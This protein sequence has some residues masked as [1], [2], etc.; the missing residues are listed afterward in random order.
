M[1]TSDTPLHVFVATPAYDHKLDSRYVGCLLRLWSLIH[2]LGGR[3]T[4]PGL[5]GKE[6][7]HASWWSQADSL[8]PRSRNHYVHEFLQGPA[9][10]TGLP[11]YTHLLS[12]DADIIFDPRVVPAMAA[13]GHDV[14]CCAYPKKGINW[15][16]VSYAARKHEQVLERFAADYAINYGVPNGSEIEAVNCSVPILDA[17]TGFLMTSRKA[18][19]DMAYAY[20]QTLCISDRPGDTYLQCMLGLFDTYTDESLRPL[21]EDYAFSRRWQKLGGKVWLYLGPGCQLAHVGTHEYRGNI[22]DQAVPVGGDVSLE[23]SLP[24]DP[25]V[26]QYGLVMLERYQWAARALRGAKRIADAC[27]GPGYGMPILR[28]ATGAE[29]VGFDRS[30][31][32]AATSA[33]RGFGHVVVT[34]LEKAQLSSFD[35]VCTLETIE[36]LPDPIAWLQSLPPRVTRLALSAPCIPTKHKNKWHLWDFTSQEVMHIIRALGWTVRKHEHQNHDVVLIYAER[37]SALVQS[38]S[39]DAVDELARAFDER[40]KHMSENPCT[41]PDCIS[42]RIADLTL[43]KPVEAA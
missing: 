4:I 22:Y 16:R 37:G 14:I 1:T 20:P 36:H 5:D 42:C 38:E 9:V 40:A 6:P 27:S 15:D 30:A 34:D 32:N 18:I 10:S 17:A 31:E 43:P 13:T 25:E 23:S 41:E 29:V 26:G 35:A 24:D 12:I 11:P 2:G 8:V 3:A 33:A 28:E 19:L 39:K 21:S 7:A